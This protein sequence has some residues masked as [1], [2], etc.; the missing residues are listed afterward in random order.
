MVGGERLVGHEGLPDADGIRMRLVDGDV[1]DAAARLVG[2][3][4]ST[5][6]RRKDRKCLAHGV[7]EGRIRPGIPVA[8]DEEGLAEVPR[9]AA[10][11]LGGC[12]ASLLM[13]RGVEGGDGES[14]KFAG[15][16]GAPLMHA[17][18][19]ASDDRERL[20]PREEGVAVLLATHNTRALD[21]FPTR[22]R[23]FGDVTKSL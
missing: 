15:E 3:T 21:F 7:E 1:V 6:S 17:R 8:R 18:Q 5:V 4:G 13:E 19:G 22:V 2:G 12:E 14:F 9:K 23:F 16:N 11:R 20:L 10:D